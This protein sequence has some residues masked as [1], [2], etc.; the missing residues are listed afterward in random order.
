[1]PKRF[2]DLPIYKLDKRGGAP[3]GELPSTLKSSQAVA[4]LP[5]SLH[6]N[7]KKKLPLTFYSP[8]TN[9]A[10]VT[11]ASVEL[12]TGRSGSPWQ[13]SVEDDV[14]KSTIGQ[15]RHQ[16]ARQSYNLVDLNQQVNDQGFEVGNGIREKRVVREIKKVIKPKTIR[17]GSTLL[18][19]HSSNNTVSRSKSSSSDKDANY[20]QG[21]KFKIKRQVTGFDDKAAIIP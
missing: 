20:I 8:R 13:D 12:G 18:N 3:D 19:V 17:R 16:K 4:A 6:P 7:F 21:K 15:W 1:M 11:A 9:F 14:N 10:E 2:D 5:H